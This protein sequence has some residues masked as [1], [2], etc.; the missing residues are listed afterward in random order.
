MCSE[1]EPWWTAQVKK[2]AAVAAPSGLVRSWWLFASGTRIAREMA[3]VGNHDHGVADEADL[4]GA[5]GY[6]FPGAFMRPLR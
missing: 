3:E 1:C 5:H 2:I 6:A 4:P